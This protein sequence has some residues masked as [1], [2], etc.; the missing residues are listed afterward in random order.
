MFGLRKY[1]RILM[2]ASVFNLLRYVILGKWCKENPKTFQK[3]LVDSQDSTVPTL[4][5]RT[6]M[7][8]SENFSCKMADDKYLAIL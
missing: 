2:F 5:T 8:R 3:G 1:I 4:R 6:I 7:Q